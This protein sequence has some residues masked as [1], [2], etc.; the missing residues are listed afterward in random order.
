MYVMFVISDLLIFIIAFLVQFFP[1]KQWTVF[2]SWNVS[3]YVFDQHATS[4]KITETLHYKG[5]HLTDVASIW[6]FQKEITVE[7][8]FQTLKKIRENENLEV[9][10]LELFW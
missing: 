1:A 9:K 8:Y 6:I 3:F 4:S 5:Q 2:I 10:L 7:K